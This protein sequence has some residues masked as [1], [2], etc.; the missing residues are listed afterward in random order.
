MKKI[1]ENLAWIVFAFFAVIFFTLGI[2]LQHLNDELAR[3]KVETT[4]TI[5]DITSNG[6]DHDV[7]V[8]YVVDNVLY[9][10]PLNSYSSSYY[11]GQEITV[12]YDKTNPSRLVSI[13]PSF[14]IYAFY[15]IGGAFVIATGMFIYSKYRKKR[16]IVTLKE[17]GNVVN[18]NY[19]ST[20]INR[21]YSVNGRN[22]YNIICEWNNSMDGKKYIF[23]SKNIWIDPEIIIKERNIK[24]FRVY[25]NPN[26]LKQYYVDIDMLLDNVVDFR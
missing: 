23:K 10:V 24:T 20:Q 15:G 9:H 19:V 17:T 7:R 21:N 16:L 6:D 2:L 25:M 1:E 3:N 14:V 4:A 18:A 5:V 22:P 26:N 13:T 11:I 8:S 12:Y